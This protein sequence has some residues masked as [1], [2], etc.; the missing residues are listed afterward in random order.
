MGG[1]LACSQGYTMA[2]SLLDVLI[3]GCTVFG[4]VTAINIRQPDKM[5][6]TVPQPGAGG[7]YT[8]QRTGTNVTGCRDKNNLNVNLAACLDAAAYSAFFK[9]AT[10]RV[11]IKKQ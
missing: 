11:I 7:P 5:D 10:G 6:L 3:G 2:N 1:A 9:L 8:L 4:F